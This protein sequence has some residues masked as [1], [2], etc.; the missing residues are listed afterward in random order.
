LPQAGVDDFH[1]GVAKRARDDFGAAVVSVQ[2]GLGNDD[3]EFTHP[4]NQTSAESDI[5]NPQSAI[6]NPQF[7]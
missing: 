3:S 4:L 1:A 5:R 7:R 6:R 2:T